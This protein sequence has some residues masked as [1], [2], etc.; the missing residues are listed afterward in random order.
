MLL[1]EDEATL[2]LSPAWDMERAR[3]ESWVRRFRR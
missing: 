1:L 3:E 2:F